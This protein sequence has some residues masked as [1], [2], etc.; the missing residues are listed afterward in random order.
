MKPNPQS[1]E[2]RYQEFGFKTYG[3][4]LSKQDT[5]FFTYDLNN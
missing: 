5:F 1:C 3:Y 2:K 4:S